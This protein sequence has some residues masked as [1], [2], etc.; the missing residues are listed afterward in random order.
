MQKHSPDNNE[1]ILINSDNNVR[2]VEKTM[3]LSNKHSTPV[4]NEISKRCRIGGGFDIF[5]TSFKRRN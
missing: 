3:K 5:T 1:L 4:R 2:R